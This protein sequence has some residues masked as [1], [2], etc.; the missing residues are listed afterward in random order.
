MCV[1]AAQD[2]ARRLGSA[3]KHSRAE[4][5]LCA[6]PSPPRP[7]SWMWA[8]LGRALSLWLQ[9]QPWLSERKQTGKVASPP[10]RLPRQLSFLCGAQAGKGP[11]PNPEFNNNFLSFVFKSPGS[12]MPWSLGKL[13]FSASVVAGGGCTVAYYLIQSKYPADPAAPAGFL[14]TLSALLLHQR[15]YLRCFQHISERRRGLFL[16][17]RSPFPLALVSCTSY[18]PSFSWSYTCI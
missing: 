1:L 12:K 3:P 5:S 18:G 17:A 7:G 6:Q 15:R 8:T 14:L 13:V 2:L 11:W 10:C 9:S 4:C 16:E